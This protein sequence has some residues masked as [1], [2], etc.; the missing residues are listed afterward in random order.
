MSLKKMIPEV[1]RQ[2]LR[3]VRK[4]FQLLGRSCR[5]AA[6]AFRPTEFGYRLEIGTFGEFELAYRTGTADELVI[7]QALEED[8][9]FKGISEYRPAPNHVIVDVG[10]HIGLFSLLAGQRSPQGRIFA[11][12]CSRET[13]NYLRLNVA[14]NKVSNIDIS[15]LALSDKAGEVRLFHAD[16]NW[17]HSI[18]K[19]LSSSGEAVP[20][21][22]LVNF[23]LTKKIE[24]C[25]LMKLNCE[26][27]EFPILL[28]TPVEVLRRVDVLFIAYH[29]DLRGAYTIEQLIEHLNSAGF[30]TR[31]YVVFRHGG[32][33]VAY[34][35]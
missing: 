18:M 24:H 10:A 16:G 15:R 21:D 23:F 26:G 22:T 27:A 11:I 5:N 9:F 7:H 14:L 34:R 32:W 6:L 13:Y 33:M 17:G 35:G 2:P 1:L 29:N 4:R 31:E 30:K 28:S 19:P 25:D 20:A 3:S 12:E 8:L